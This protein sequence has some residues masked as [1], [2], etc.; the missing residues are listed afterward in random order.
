VVSGAPSRGGQLQRGCGAAKGEWL[1]VLHADTVLSEGWG[2][3][4]VQHLQTGDAGW[5]SLQ[6]DG[7]GVKGKFVAFWANLRSHLGLPYGDQ[8]LLV[9]RTLYDVV[10]GYRDIP[11]MEDVAL[12]RALKGK[13]RR[14]DA[15]AITSAVKYQKQ[16]WLKRG[17]RNLITLLQYFSG[18]DPEVLAERYR[19]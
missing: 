12:S 7:G 2:N 16:G 4:A 18:A 10:G 11:L 14:I 8:G 9:S 1:L 19:R 5:F 6:F 13:L 15:T 17:G 3:A